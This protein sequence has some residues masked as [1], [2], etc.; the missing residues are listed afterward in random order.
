MALRT[1][2]HYVAVVKGTSRKIAGVVA[3]PTIRGRW[4][5]Y[6]RFTR[7]IGA[8]VAGRAVAGNGA[9]VERRIGE[10][11]R[12]AMAD[13]ALLVS[14]YVV[15]SLA[16]RDDAVVAGAAIAGNTGVIV[17]AVGRGGDEFFGVVAGVA[18]GG[19][20]L[21]EDRLADRS[22]TVMAAAAG[23]ENFCVIDKRYRRKTNHRV[24]RLA[25]VPRRQVITG[26][27]AD[28]SAVALGAGRIQ[29]IV[30]EVGRQIR[31]FTG[32]D[33]DQIACADFPGRAHFE[34][35]H[36][37]AALVGDKT[38]VYSGCITQSRR[39]A[40]RHTGKHPL[41]CQWLCAVTVGAGTVQGDRRCHRHDLDGARVGRKIDQTPI[42]VGEAR[43]RRI[44]IVGRWRHNLIV[45]RRR[46]VAGIA[47]ATTAT[48]HQHHGS[49]NR[50]RHS[51]NG[52]HWVFSLE[53]NVCTACARFPVPGCC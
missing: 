28:Q 24:T 20:D 8:V 45:R 3:D 23:T 12:I 40:L 52:F 35:G 11:H 29:T 33:R 30:I 15:R 26:L 16:G 37:G 49:K 43:I 6:F 4:Y 13:V 19:R 14:G 7:R 22:D 51:Q 42:G 46:C 27:A 41:V 17:G 32:I 53:L 2:V 9:M 44:R 50:A 1:I 21:V 38:G 47:W 25:G 18:L 34:L 39:A 10:A 48:R 31:G 36:V 5:V